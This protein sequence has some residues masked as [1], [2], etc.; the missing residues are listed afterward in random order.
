[1]YIEVIRSQYYIMVDGFRGGAIGNTNVQGEEVKQL[2]VLAN[3]LFIN[4]LKASFN[5]GVMIS[6]ENEQLIEVDAGLRGKYV[7]AFDPL[8]GSSNIDC[9]VSIGSIFGIWR[10]VFVCSLCV[11]LS[12][13]V[14]TCLLHASVC[15]YVLVRYDV[16]IDVHT[17]V[18]RQ[19]LLC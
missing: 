11:C 16:I 1:M 6:E 5:V 4:M 13:S 7:V 17:G 14:C 12:V 2:D 18:R 15:V 8:D 3:D 9:L 10:K 19:A